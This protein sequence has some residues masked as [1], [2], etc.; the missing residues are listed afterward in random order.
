MSNIPTKSLL[1]KKKNHISSGRYASARKHS[2]DKEEDFMYSAAISAST[3]SALLG[4]VIGG[5]LMGA[6]LG[7]S[8]DGDL[9]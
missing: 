8:L 9:F 2:S 7:D 4:Y 1:P 5:S 6:L 3:D